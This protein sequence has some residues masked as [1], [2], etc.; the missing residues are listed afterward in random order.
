MEGRLSSTDILASCHVVVAS[1]STVARR[2]RVKVN[3]FLDARTHPSRSEIENGF[4]YLR[5]MHGATGLP[6]VYEE[7]KKS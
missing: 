6:Y 3:H 1:R 5:L 2:E 4:E 7:E